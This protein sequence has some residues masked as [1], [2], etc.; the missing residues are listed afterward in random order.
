MLGKLIPSNL[1]NSVNQFVNSPQ[2]VV[3]I[4][5]WFAFLGLIAVPYIYF[6]ARNENYPGE[7]LNGLQWTLGVVTI[8]I[9]L[10]VLTV[11]THVN[12]VIALAHQTT[13]VVLFGL[14]IFILHRLRERDRTLS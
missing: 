14:A 12:I 2:T 1:F 8:Q 13:A 10:G 4:H 7:I 6:R 5:R 11:L 3:F 9:L